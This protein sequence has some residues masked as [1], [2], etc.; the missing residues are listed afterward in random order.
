MFWD[1]PPFLLIHGRSQ[2]AQKFLS[3]EATRGEAC[4]VVL[5]GCHMAKSRC[6]KWKEPW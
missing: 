1:V 3:V 4:A 2:Q 6:P 5:R